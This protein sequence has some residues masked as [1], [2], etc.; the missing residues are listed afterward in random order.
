VSD[1]SPSSIKT[2]AEF[3]KLI[4]EAPS[5]E[6]IKKLMMDRALAQGIVVPDPM[7]PNV[8]LPVESP[9]APTPH[10]SGKHATT[11]TV[12]GKLHVFE[13]ATKQEADAKQLE[14]FRSLNPTTPAEPARDEAGRFTAADQG[15]RDEA[16][17]AEIARKANLELAFKRGDIPVAEYIAQSGAIESYLENQG[18]SVEMLKQQSAER[19][20]AKQ[21]EQS[22][23]EASTAFRNSPAGADW[24]GGQDNLARIGSIIEQ[25]GDANPDIER[26]DKVQVLTHAWNIM[27]RNDAQ[28]KALEEAKTPEDIRTAL[29]MNSRD[30][31]GGSSSLFGTR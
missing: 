31:R 29:G 15:K 12:N 4:E 3:N 5:A 28:T 23:A 25:L 24:P 26:E 9:A 22:W 11:I 7:N 10:V 18:V 16:E 1:L 14:F 13:G 21:Y 6:I 2:D 30:I 8:L 27:K 20:A 17:A 19:T